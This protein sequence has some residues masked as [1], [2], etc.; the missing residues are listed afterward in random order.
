MEKWKPIIGFE[1]LYECSN[2]GNLRSVTKIVR[3]DENSTKI[4]KGRVIKQQMGTSGYKCVTFSKDGK[5]SN[6]R[7][8]RLIAA[9]FIKNPNEKAQ[10]NHINEIKTDNRSEN[11]E[12]VTHHENQLH[13]TRIE[14]LKASTDN[15]GI[16]NPMYGR[17]GALNPKSKPV[18]QYCKKGKKINEFDSA[19]TVNREL[20]FNSS[21]V[22][23]AAKGKLKTAHGYV[24]KYK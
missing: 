10:V 1:G 16:K 17:I 5:L 2:L 13:G 12:W 24:W 9:S 4:I 7:V 8:H 21:S 22:S 18:I 19:A 6:H 14:R 23:R 3:R 11:L 15:N 20:G